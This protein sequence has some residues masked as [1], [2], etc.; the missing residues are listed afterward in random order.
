MS[1]LSEK[2]FWDAAQHAFDTE[3][4][5]LTILP[6]ERCNLSCSY[7]YETFELGKMRPL[8]V[9]AVQRLIRRRGPHLRHLQVDWFGGEPL[10]AMDVIEAI[11]GTAHTAA[12]ENPHLDYTGSATTN[13][14]L[15]TES[16]AR[17][18][19]NVGV[20]LLHVSLDGPA[21]AHDE[22]R[23]DRKGRGTFAK[24]HANL[25][26]IRDSDVDVKV[27]LR[28]HVTPR[29][30]KMLPEFVDELVQSFIPDERFDALFL[31]DC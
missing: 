3:A 27:K 30:H 11:A 10:L 24:L 22:T 9:E 12:Q 5:E 13:G 4:L 25:E 20:R 28:V 21:E 15:L 31:P 23:I 26:A 1:A 7:C 19:S 8:V 18:L 14:V 16:V 6:T 17:R 29:N 2:D